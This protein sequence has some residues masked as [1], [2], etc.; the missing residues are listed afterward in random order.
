[1]RD[2]D[3]QKTHLD[4]RDLGHGVDDLARDQMKAA[5]PRLEVDSPLD[6][7][8]GNATAPT[9]GGLC[10][11]ATAMAVDTLEISDAHTAANLTFSS[12]RGQFDANG[13]VTTSNAMPGRYL[14]RA[15]S[16]PP[17]WTFK[18]AMYNG[19]DAS[20]TPVEIDTTDIAGVVFIF[21]DQAIQISGS[22]QN[23]S[24]ADADDALL[25][26]K[27]SISFFTHENFERRGQLE[28]N[29]GDDQFVVVL[30]VHV[31]GFSLG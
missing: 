25:V 22:V 30:S 17:G 8:A 28:V 12:M 11:A 18:S 23:A 19:R 10:S 31:S 3:V 29:A 15:S 27:Q 1:M 5:R 9:R 24:G 6:P 26:T 21:T 4:V 20:V 13:Q 16:S 14:I 7:H 2:Q